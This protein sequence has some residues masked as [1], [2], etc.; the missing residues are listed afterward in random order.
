[1]L[2]AMRATQK[3]RAA[4]LGT[5]MRMMFVSHHRAHLMGLMVLTDNTTHGGR[6]RRSDYDEDEDQR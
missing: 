4:R 3:R 2:A 6:G 1:M 5:T